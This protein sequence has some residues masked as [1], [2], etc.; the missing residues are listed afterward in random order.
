MSERTFTLDEANALLPY[1]APALIELREKVEGASRLGA[2][3]EAAAA[4]NGLAEKKAE[5]A[6]LME[7]VDELLGRVLEWRVILRDVASGLVD[8][9]ATAGGENI[10]YCWR[11]G[12]PQ[13]THWHSPADG[14][15]GRRT[16]A[17][18]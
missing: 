18:L 4:G 6:R 2:E 9:P 7:R 11:L 5:Q 10:L 17:E 12:E 1:L 8:F 3:I 15:L 16:I 13:V 14:F